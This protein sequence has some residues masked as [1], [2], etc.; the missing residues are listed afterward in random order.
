DGERI[1]RVTPVEE[2]RITRTAG[3]ETKLF[4][5]PTV[6]GLRRLSLP[7]LDGKGARLLTDSPALESLAEL[8]LGK[9][10]RWDIAAKDAAGLFASTRLA[11]LRKLRVRSNY[12]GGAVAT[13]LAN[14]SHVRELDELELLC[15]GMQPREFAAILASPKLERL[16]I[17]NVQGNG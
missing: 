12:V 5:S 15:T 3:L 13:T 9:L 11:S 14:H 6:L 2:L 4:Q 10:G 16:R 17:L 1:Q 8:S 7:H